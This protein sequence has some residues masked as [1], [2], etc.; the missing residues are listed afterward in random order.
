MILRV[1]QLY[2]PYLITNSL[3]PTT[4][5]FINIINN[6]KSSTPLNISTIQLF[7]L[8]ARTDKGLLPFRN[9]Y[10]QQIT[11]KPRTL[12]YFVIFMYNLS[13]KTQ[14]LRILTT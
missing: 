4:F 13:A 9:T 11:K 14:N 8:T 10:H 2:M 6:F 5:S 12:D 3:H 1:S 7:C